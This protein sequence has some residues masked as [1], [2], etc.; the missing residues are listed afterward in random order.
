MNSVVVHTDRQDAL[1]DII[2]CADMFKPLCI[3]GKG[4]YGTTLKSQFTDSEGN[5]ENY[6][7]KYLF[8]SHV[9]SSKQFHN[10]RNEREIL[11]QLN[12]PFVMKFFGKLSTLQNHFF[13]AENVTHFS[14][15][16]LS[17]GQ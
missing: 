10:V 15:R 16:G 6:A 4:S 3:L 9:A 2:L 17:N 13:V 8:K 11:S 5:T 7:L 1:K 14:F 12:H